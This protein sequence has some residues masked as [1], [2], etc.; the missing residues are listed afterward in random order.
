ME[1]RRDIGYAIGS[2]LLAGLAVALIT[3]GL[4]SR[5]TPAIE[6][7]RKDNV[8]TLDAARELLEVFVESAGEPLDLPRR[9]RAEKT[10][11]RMRQ[12]LTVDD[13]GT[14]VLAV[15]DAVSRAIEG[16]RPELARLVVAVEALSAANTKAMVEADIE[17]QRLG[18]AGA[19]TA[20]I[21]GIAIVLLWLF[22]RTRLE[23]RVIR[24]VLEASRV[25][26][27]NRQGDKLARC[28]ALAGTVELERTLR[29]VNKLLDRSSREEK[30]PPDERERQHAVALVAMLEMRTGPWAVLSAD[31][32]VAAN[33]A[34]HER[35]A[36]A[37][38]ARLLERWRQHL[39]LGGE[40]MT[41]LDQGRLVL[42]D[43][44]ALAKRADA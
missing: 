15:T 33:E 1:V 43:L 14:L 27:A 44:D 7:I 40:G 18:E 3:I 35:L 41:P 2:L 6:R 5:M 42:L 13:E 25:L 11:E 36:E 17:A 32:L 10:L 30:K 28:R 20:S 31:G 21:G 26:D 16:D 19:W 12:N 8:V 38:G 29:L 22:A 34:A 4:F 39:H 23:R 24:P 37:D 9:E